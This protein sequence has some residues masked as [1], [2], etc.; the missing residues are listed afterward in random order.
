[1]THQ[2]QGIIKNVRIF[3]GDREYPSQGESEP[4]MTEEVRYFLE[5]FQ[6][7]SEKKNN[8]WSRLIGDVTEDKK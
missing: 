4:E 8:G 2:F 7:M 6:R 1:M 3:I 5:E